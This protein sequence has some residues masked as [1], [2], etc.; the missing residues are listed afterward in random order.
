VVAVEG[1]AGSQEVAEFFGGE[2]ASA[3]VAK[4]LVG[5]Q[6][7]LRGLDLTD[8]VGGE[9]VF[10]AGRFQDAQEDRATGHHPAVAELALEVVLPAQHD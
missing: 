2:G 4:D 8:R 9:Q 1:P 6:A 3:L 5:V 7:G 10:L